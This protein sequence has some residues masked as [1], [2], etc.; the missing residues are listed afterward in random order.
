MTEA[1]KCRQTLAWAFAEAALAL[2][3]VA[4]G[5]PIPDEAVWALAEALDLIHERACARLARHDSTGSAAPE[6]AEHPAVA[7][8]LRQ[9]QSRAPDVRNVSAHREVTA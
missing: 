4:A 6:D 5:Y 3:G 7:H 8:L 1:C 2:G 9:L